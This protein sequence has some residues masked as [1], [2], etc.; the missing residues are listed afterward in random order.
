MIGTI[1]VEALATFRNI[2][3]VADYEQAKVTLGQEAIPGYPDV[4]YAFFGPVMFL[5]SQ[6]QTY[7]GFAAATTQATLD[8]AIAFDKTQGWQIYSASKGISMWLIVT[9][10]AI[11]GLVLLGRKKHK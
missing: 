11:L 9:G 4:R 7:Y 6:G 5:T 10:V 2:A 8:E 3:S 1:G